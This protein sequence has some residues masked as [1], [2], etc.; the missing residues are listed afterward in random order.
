MTYNASHF[1]DWFLRTFCLK[2]LS[3]KYTQTFP[4]LSM[5]D[6]RRCFVF[7]NLFFMFYKWYIIYLLLYILFSYFGLSGMICSSPS[8][9]VNHCKSRIAHSSNCT[10]DNKRIHKARKIRSITLCRRASASNPMSANIKYL[11]FHL[12]KVKIKIFIILYQICPFLTQWVR[13]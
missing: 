4:Q 6:G 10:Q 7:N 2:I 12:P 1:V 11:T 13:D 5:Y 3:G 8:F 9:P